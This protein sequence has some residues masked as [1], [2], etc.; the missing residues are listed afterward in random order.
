MMKKV[1]II[2]NILMVLSLFYVIRR[3]IN[4][5]WS[6]IVT[7]Q[8]IAKILFCIPLYSLIILFNVL[9]WEFL[10][11]IFTKSNFSIKKNYFYFSYIYTKSNLYKYLPGNVFQYIGRNE[12][13][14]ILQLEHINVAAASIMEIIFTFFAG[15]LSSIILIGNFTIQYFRDNWHQILPMFILITVLLILLL[16]LFFRRERKMLLGLIMDFKKIYNSRDSLV[17]LM[18]CFVIYLFNYIFVTALFIILMLNCYDIHLSLSQIRIVAGGFIF[19]WLAGY[20]TPGAPGG[21]G[22][23]ELIMTTLFKD[24]SFISTDIVLS[25]IS[26][27]RVVNI[28]GDILSFLI[29]LVIFN[30]FLRNRNFKE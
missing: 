13:C 14:T 25:S 4:V 7:K 23:R 11:K 22:V 16:F 18:H 9:P 29:I 5:D 24:N 21:I 10:V 8:N 20:I 19:S 26:L 12:I 2:G 30:V 15:L 3:I 27:F 1:K 28:F 17:S 6:V